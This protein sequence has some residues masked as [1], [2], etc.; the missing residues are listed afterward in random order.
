VEAHAAGD[1]ADSESRVGSM[2]LHQGD[3][4]DMISKYFD[5]IEVGE[6]NVTAGRTI[7]EGD[8]VNFAMF[9]GDWHPLHT[10]AEYAKSGPFGERIAHG[11][12]VI[13]VASGLV[14][15]ATGP[16]LAFYGMDKLR[17]MGATKIGDTI[18]VE[19]E[20]LA[21]EERNE[22][23]GL[24]TSKQV[25]KNQRGEDLAVST[26]KMLVAKQKNGKKEG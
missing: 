12:L 18:H 22:S 24:V 7:T 4:G 26:W 1:S 5:E 9:T 6:R 25:I 14:P 11:L 16:V 21:K 23:S 2:P 20:V 3:R 15:L 13:S 8:I 17:F 10:D 19:T